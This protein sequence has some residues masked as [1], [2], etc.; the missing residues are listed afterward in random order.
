MRWKQ[1]RGGG[2]EEKLWPRFLHR[3]HSGRCTVHTA[4]TEKRK[5]HFTPP[6]DQETVSVYIR[7]D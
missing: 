1:G 2:L 4:G 5:K 7:L 3:T 6:K